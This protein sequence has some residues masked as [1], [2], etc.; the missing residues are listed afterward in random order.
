MD[1]RDS[2]G[3]PISQVI[4]ATQLNQHSGLNGTVRIRIQGL[5]NLEPVQIAKTNVHPK[6][7]NCSRNL[8]KSPKTSPKPSSEPN[9]IDEI[10]IRAS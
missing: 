8:R 7:L 10:S 2:F 3:T 9:G 1:H 6:I 4:Y 5:L